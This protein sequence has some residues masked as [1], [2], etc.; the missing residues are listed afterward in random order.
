MRE[1]LHSSITKELNILNDDKKLSNQQLFTTEQSPNPS[2]PS[3]D[4]FDFREMRPANS[5]EYKKSERK[6]SNSPV[7]IG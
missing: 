6:K 3:T 4:V 5:Q 2:S 1:S 7:S